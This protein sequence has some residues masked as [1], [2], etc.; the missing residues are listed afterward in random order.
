VALDVALR[1]EKALKLADVKIVLP[2]VLDSA[3]YKHDAETGAFALVIYDQ[4]TPAQLPRANTLFIGRIPPGPVWRGGKVADKPGDDAAKAAADD[5][6]RMVAAPQVIDWDRG[7][8]LLAHVE[9]GNVD[10]VDSLVLDPPPGA[11]VLIESTGGPIAAIAPR[12]SYQDAVL[13]FEI[14]GKGPDGTTTVNTNWPR[15]LSFPTFW[16]NVLEYLAGA[17]EDNEANNV[18]PGR[19]MPIAVPPGADKLTVIDPV[20][21]PTT[22]ARGEQDVLQFH[23]TEKPGVYQ[24]RSGDKVVQRFAVNLFDRAESDVRVRPSQ[25]PDSP[26]VQ[27]ADIRIGNVDVAAVVDRT[28]SRREMWKTLL[29]CALFVLL[30]EWYIYNRRV[31]L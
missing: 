19:S 29:L 27:P 25:D 3:D 1:T 28:P 8:P 12:D 6:N 14:V 18:K 2:D 11:K 23:G 13:G 31:Y 4:C 30:A 7:S 21:E 20:G 9:L 10:F 24:V 16:L 17:S 5:A 22:L 15:R 26:T